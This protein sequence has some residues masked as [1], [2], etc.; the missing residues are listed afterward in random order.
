MPRSPDHAANFWR[1]SDRHHLM[2]LAQTK[3]AHRLS[4]VGFLTVNALGER[5]MKFFVSH[6][7]QPVMSST[8]LPRLA[9]ISSGE[10]SEASALTVA[11]TTLMGLR[12]P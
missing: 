1:V 6:D 7:V 4:D 8:R 9:A 10:R 11:R 2:P 5:D 3:S 12:E